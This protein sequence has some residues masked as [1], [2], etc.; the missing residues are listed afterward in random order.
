[1]KILRSV[2]FKRSEIRLVEPYPLTRTLLVKPHDRGKK[3]IEYLHERFSYVSCEEWQRRLDNKWIWFA[4]GEATASSLLKPNQIIYHHSPK[5]LEPSVPDAVTVIKESDEWMVVYKPAPMPMHQGGRYYKNTL[6]Y[7]LSEMGAEGLSIVHRLD[8]VTSGLVI[9]AKN[10]E[11]A[12]RLQIAF[13]EKR[14]EKWYYA[15]VSGEMQ[16][17]SI[18]VDVPIARK[19][20]FVFE[21]GH[22]LSNGKSAVTLIER[23]ASMN[24]MSL[25]KCNPLTGRTHQI[26]LHLREAGI[27]IVDDPIYGPDG[28]NTGKKLQN[29]AISLQ[30]SGI[31]LD[32]LSIHADIDA[33]KAWFKTDIF[34]H[35][36]S[37]NP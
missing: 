12:N 8:A 14:V 25:V 21:C 9:L 34:K 18:T 22:Q 13:T 28:D 24:G 33:P 19:R 2:N 1:M 27:P 32:D 3:L 30:S 26:R 6:T 29:R 31:I 37:P 23:V 16:D 15:L 7:I 35:K 5:V 36:K 10:R 20:G 11:V 17:E 4:E